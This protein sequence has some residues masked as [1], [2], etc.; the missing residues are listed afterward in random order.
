MNRKLIQAIAWLW[1]GTMATGRGTVLEERDIRAAA[2]NFVARTFFSP[3]TELAGLEPPDAGMPYW[4]VPLKPGG[5]LILSPE[6]EAIPVVGFSTTG[7]LEMK[8]GPDNSLR[9]MLEARGSRSRVDPRGA[10][11]W[12]RLLAPAGIKAL[13][14][15]APSQVLQE[16]LLA[17]HWSQWK[18]YNLL[19]PAV[20]NGMEGYGGRAPVGCVPV[21]MGQVLRYYSWPASGTGG[22]SFADTNGACQ[23]TYSAGWTNAIPWE[24]MKDTYEITCEESPDLVNP[25]AEL[26]AHLGVAAEMDYEANGSASDVLTLAR[27]VVSHLNYTIGDWVKAGNSRFSEI[28]EAEIGARRPVIINLLTDSGHTAVADG[29]A[30]DGAVKY[31][32]LN[33]GW[34]GKNDGWYV[35]GETND[36]AF[37][38][39]IISTLHPNAK[40]PFVS[41][42]P[43]FFE[44]TVTNHATTPLSLEVLGIGTNGVNY[45]L[46]GSDPWIAVTPGAGVAGGTSGQHPRHQVTIDP[47]PLAS[48][49]NDGYILI[50]GNATNLPRRVRIRVYQP[51]PPAIL[52]QPRDI[53]T[54]F[55]TNQIMSLSAQA[56]ATHTPCEIFDPVQY[57]WTFNGEPMA[58]QVYSWCYTIGY[59]T[60]QCEA[61]SLGGRVL[62]R[63]AT[64]A[65]EKPGSR[66]TVAQ[67]SNTTLKLRLENIQSGHVTLETSTDLKSWKAL[68]TYTIAAGQ[69]AG[70][71]LNVLRTDISR[72]YRLR[73]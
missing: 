10:S 3:N 6:S 50:S 39:A 7:G 28:L 71:E 53:T 46:T 66:I 67:F 63:A 11:S 19:C 34:G 27:K 47:Q 40:E 14:V 17:T 2:S 48:G 30:A 37:Y 16:P 24:A 35:V 64:V 38:D 32:H 69:V 65:M 29:L 12:R 15:N 55:P 21:A 57:Q 22:D 59:G 49:I 56:G 62:S 31:V 70:L 4:T 72:F 20:T 18:P 44:V 73:E 42:N 5:F 54:R 51:D 36:P 60:Y 68:G 26:M 43:D 8:P 13:G 23:G 25:V 9:K 58:G 1:L 52:E 41:S 61:A 45:T 33:F